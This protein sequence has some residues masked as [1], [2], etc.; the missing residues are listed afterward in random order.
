[1]GLWKP[2]GCRVWYFSFQHNGRRKRG[3][4][5]TEDKTKAEAI[6]ALMRAKKKGGSAGEQLNSTIDALLGE[7]KAPE[8][9]E[10]FQLDT[11]ATRLPRLLRKE[12]AGSRFARLSDAGMLD[13][14]KALKRFAAWVAKH[15]RSVSQCSDVTVSV[16][17]RYVRFLNDT[18]KKDGGKR[19]AAA[20]RGQANLLSAVWSALDWI[21][22]DK[23][24]ANP[25]K[26]A[27]PAREP[28]EE[29]HGRAFSIEEVKRL[30][31]VAP[32]EALKRAMLI[33]M[34]TGMRLAD[35][36]RIRW[37]AF[38]WDA[39]KIR[40]QPGK[41]KHSTAVKPSIPLHSDLKK[42]LY[43]VQG[44][45]DALVV[46]CPFINWHALPRVWRKMMAEA[47]IE[48]QEGEWLTFHCLRHTFGTWL[49]M[50]GATE[51]ERMRLGGWTSIETANIYNH[52]ESRARA[53]LDA[54]PSVL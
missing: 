22:G 25:W 38:D 53:L 39:G 44:L 30:L 1:M 50:N 16:A 47:G 40:Y 26:K 37:G 23:T 19:T 14:Q 31:A 33:S 41:T 27:R 36:K 45:P 20:V 7:T 13:R 11:L 35:V 46:P 48:K 8:K 24:L 29:T 21:A 34:Y 54:M 4:L 42:A 49:A 3:S 6:F 9:Q 43:P 18:P 52:D 2:Q 32:N 12:A 5:H 10:G 28:S 51:A 17:R 15:E